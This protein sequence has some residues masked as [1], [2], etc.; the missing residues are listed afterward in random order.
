MAWLED[1]RRKLGRADEHLSELE[2]EMGKQLDEKEH[3]VTRQAEMK[4][5][6]E[7]G[8]ETLM[9]PME[10]VDPPEMPAE[11]SLHAAYTVPASVGGSK[12]SS[13]AT[14]VRSGGGV[15]GSPAS[16]CR[17]SLASSNRPPV[18]VQ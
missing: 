10:L 14:V 18:S 13:P 9:G 3:T 1:A 17:R 4:I 16:S 2:S 11:W 15:D 12:A 8:R 7:G 5:T 6:E